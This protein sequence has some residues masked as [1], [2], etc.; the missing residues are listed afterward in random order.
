M[1]GPLEALWIQQ[2]TGSQPSS[3][4]TVAA[5]DPDTGITYGIACDHRAAAD[6]AEALADPW[7]Q[8]PILYPEPWQILWTEEAQPA[9]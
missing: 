9:L 8:P 4:L 3:V 6:I 1:V 7:E 5:L 2:P